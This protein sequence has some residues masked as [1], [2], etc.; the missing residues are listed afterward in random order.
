MIV[1]FTSLHSGGATFMDWSWHWLKG[2]DYFWNLKK[3]WITLVDDPIKVKNA[4]GHEKNHPGSFESCQKFLEVAV[5]ESHDTGKD[6]SFYPFIRPTADNLNDEMDNINLL[7]KQKVGVVVIKKTQEFPYGSA[8]TDMKDDEHTLL[9]SDPDLPSDIDRKKL[10]E[11]VSMRMV[12]QQKTWLGKIDLAFDLLDK[13]VVVVTDKEWAHQ[14]EETMIRI[15]GRLGTVID[16]GRL[17]SWRPIMQRWRENYKKAEFFYNQ[18]IPLM[19]DKI[20]AGESMDLTPFNFK[21]TEES[22]L[23]MYVMKRH[24]R[25]L[26]IPTDHFPKNTLDLHRFLK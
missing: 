6:I 21:L 5:K 24:G 9:E 11:M 1:A 20:V 22:L 19:A 17:I 8:R 13:E 14:P 15:C 23:M 12:P 4:H 10:R 7:I 18:E 16:P 3:G 25:R 2:S 26:I